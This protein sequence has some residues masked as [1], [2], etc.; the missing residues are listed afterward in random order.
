MLTE[1]QLRGLMRDLESDRVER[2][3][4][5]KKFDKFG[6]A[7]CAFAND[8]PGH[9]KPGY[10]LVGVHDNGSSAG[11]SITDE[12]LKEL[13]EL[14]ASGKLLPVP[15]LTVERIP[16]ADG[17]GEVAV[18]QVL[19]SDLPPVRFEGRVWI[20]VGPRKACAS[21]AEERL[22]I[23]R[24]VAQARTFDAR[25]CPD[26]TLR[27]LVPDLF[28]VN[29]RLRAFAPEVIEENH[30][31]LEH[32]LASLRF[33]DLERGC[34]TH[35]GVLL[36]GAE[37]RSFLDSAYI[38]F[39]RFAGTELEDEVSHSAELS[40]DL[41]TILRGLDALLPTQLAHRRTQES[42]LRERHTSQYPIRAIRELLL[43]ALIHRQYEASGPIRLHWFDDRIELQSPGG[44]YGEATPENFPERNAYRNPVL[45]ES[46]KVLGYVE[47][48]GR[49][50]RL[51]QR[52]LQ[53]NGNPPAEF[54]FDPHYVHVVLRGV[55]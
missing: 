42:L 9:R 45:A 11:L 23:E 43:N 29:Y 26:A 20:R 4:T 32:Q 33:F 52:A 19:P 30:R 25:P 31:S 22:L 12:I 6:Q 18:V 51:A 35:A 37:P 17:S 49:G 55:P 1:D 21:E 10:L 27:D 2:T 39:L 13:G 48:F 34:P 38:Q 47:R 40:G 14:R 53:A 46:L 3:I 50:V 16:L 54:K 41:L 5:T 24:R 8:L 7:I 28:L 44:L 15:V 36:F